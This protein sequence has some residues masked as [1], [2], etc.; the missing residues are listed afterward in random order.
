RI[1][2][3][4]LLVGDDARTAVPAHV[5]E[6]AYDA[7]LAAHDQRALADNIHGQI[8][9]GIRNVGNMPDD[10]PVVAEE[11]LLFQFEQR[12]RMIGPTRKPSPVPIAGNRHVTRM[13]VHRHALILFEYSFNKSTFVIEMQWLGG[14][15]KM[16]RCATGAT[17][18]E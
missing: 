13:R 9:T 4:A 3:I 2:A 10:L 17:G 5:V 7:V 1:L 8:V 15:R 12:V 16:F 18:P 6:G 11:V 14:I